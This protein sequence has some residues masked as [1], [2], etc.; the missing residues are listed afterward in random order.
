MKDFILEK[1]NDL[2]IWGQMTVW[3]VLGFV[4]GIVI[5]L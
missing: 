2:P 1:Y 3:G 5:S 4:T